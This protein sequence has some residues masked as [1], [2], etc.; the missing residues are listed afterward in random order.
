MKFYLL[1]LGILCVWRVTHL[2]NDYYTVL[3]VSDNAFSNNSMPPASDAAAK[4]K[5]SADTMPAPF[6][7][8]LLQLA[9]DGSREVNQGIGQLERFLRHQADLVGADIELVEVKGKC[10]WPFGWVFFG[11]RFA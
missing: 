7:A 3:S 10:R 5:M 9:A 6:R 4:L 2:L 1:V 8:V 11:Q